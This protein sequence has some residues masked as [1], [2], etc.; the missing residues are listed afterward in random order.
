MFQSKLCQLIELQKLAPHTKK[1][2]VRT[3]RTWVIGHFRC[4]LVCRIKGAGV[5]LSSICFDIWNLRTFLLSMTS[6]FFWFT[7]WLPVGESLNLTLSNSI[8]FWKL[9]QKSTFYISIDSEW[10]NKVEYWS[11]RTIQGGW[12]NRLFGK[13]TKFMLKSILIRQLSRNNKTN[14]TKDKPKLTRVIKSTG[15]LH[16]NYLLAKFHWTV[17]MGWCQLEFDPLKSFFS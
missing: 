11:T 6:R 16:K 12:T 2:L 3:W 7:A 5:K 14:R 9:R 13:N 10:D 17:I 4:D 1:N 8:F 15:H